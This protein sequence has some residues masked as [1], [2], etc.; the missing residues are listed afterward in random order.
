MDKPNAQN[1][2]GQGPDTVEITHEKVVQYLKK[3]LGNAIGCLNAIQSD[4]DMLNALATFML[5]RF[6]NHKLQEELKKQKN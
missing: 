4:P 5:G 3:D 1:G 2:A 6:N